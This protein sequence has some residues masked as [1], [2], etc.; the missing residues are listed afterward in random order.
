MEQKNQQKN[1]VKKTVL[2]D[3]A[4]IYNNKQEEPKV[5]ETW[6]KLSTKEKWE[7]IK[8]YYLLK[9]TI[10]LVVAAFVIYLGIV[11]LGP[12]K[13]EILYVAVLMDELNDDAVNHM[14]DELSEQFHAD[15]YHLVN[16]DDNFYF[17]AGNGSPMSGDEKLTTIMYTGAIDIIVASQE[18]FR[19]HAYYGNLKNLDAYL[20]DDIKSALS[21][22]LIMATTNANS[23]D[24]SKDNQLSFDEIMNGTDSPAYESGDPYLFG[25]DLSNCKK[26]KELGGYVDHP[27]LT[28]TFNSP[29]EENTIAFIRYLFDLPEA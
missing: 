24:T 13:K 22:K 6:K 4:S 19:R 3:D 17:Q 18:D 23:D 14:H 5:K 10:I 25:I 26:Y 27:V 16:I 11:V 7:F 1:E 2:D 29:N 9:S 21:D 28:V 15:K 12:H 8:D 20:P